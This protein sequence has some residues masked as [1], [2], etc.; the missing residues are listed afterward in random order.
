MSGN[1]SKNRLRLRAIHRATAY[2][3]LAFVA[4]HIS[5]HLIGAFG[6]ETYNH[7][8]SLLR[9]IYRNTIIEPILITAVVFQLILGLT[10]LI[11]SL[12]KE[13]PKSFWSW[14]QVVSGILIVL[15]IG[16]HLI[17]MYLARV[18]SDLDTDFYWPLSVM[19]G[20]PFTYYFIP[21]YFLM[22]SSVF[23]HAAAGLHFIGKD[24]GYSA[25]IDI[26]AKAL[27]I[28]GLLIATFIVLILNQTFFEIELPPEWLE[29]LREFVPSYSTPN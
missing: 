13:C 3:V 12:R 7:V 25:R 14:L 8:Q 26:F 27:I 10:L 1:F 6:F 4:L 17:A 23:A 9:T 15:T 29:Y 11:K 2:F 16:E 21:Y 22:V 18:V 24:R 19:D 28:L 20:P 5:N